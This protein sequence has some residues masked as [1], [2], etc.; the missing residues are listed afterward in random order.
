MFNIYQFEKQAERYPVLQEKW[1]VT[2]AE[3]VV[4]RKSLSSK[5]AA[6]ADDSLCRSQTRFV[7]AL[8]RTT[9]AE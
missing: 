2:G 1:G 3:K 6:I 4:K 9:G 7:T 8:S 5:W